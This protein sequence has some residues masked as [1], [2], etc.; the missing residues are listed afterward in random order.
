M[1]AQPQV[2]NEY[3]F[4]IICWDYFFNSIDEFQLFSPYFSDRISISFWVVLTI[5]CTISLDQ[6]SLGLWAAV[7]VHIQFLCDFVSLMLSE[8]IL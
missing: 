2:L 5:L 8:L 4:S 6:Y 7:I 3:G 1:L